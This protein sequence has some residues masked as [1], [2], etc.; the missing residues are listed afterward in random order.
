MGTQH[1]PGEP[2]VSI[3][4]VS[5][6][7]VPKKKSTCMLG[8]S[9]MARAGFLIRKVPMGFWRKTYLS[10]KRISRLA[11]EFW[12]GDSGWASIAGDSGWASI[13][14]LP[15]FALVKRLSSCDAVLKRP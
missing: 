13:D 14:R 9:H 4:S 12:P 10:S 2:N 15:K 1:L 6:F 11:P 7:K 3:T 8:R 5:T